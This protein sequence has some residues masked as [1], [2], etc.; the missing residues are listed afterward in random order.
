MLHGPAT[1]VDYVHADISSATSTS[2]AFLKPWHP[3]VAERP[4]TVFHT[5][6]VIIPADRFQ[7]ENAFCDAVNVQ[8][9]LH[10]LDA[11]RRCG[12]DILLSTTSGSIAIRP[13]RPWIA[14]WRLWSGW[15]ENYWQVLDDRDFFQPLRKHRDFYANYP[16][17]KA[18]AERTVCDANSLSMRT[19]SIRPANGVYGNPTDNTVGGPLRS[20]VYPT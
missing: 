19:G 9:T 15:P 6:A 12:A 14:P 1:L 4:L 16:A 3:S 11:A 7:L 18:S 10:V 13:V 17:A 5:A 2:A 20:T 8:G